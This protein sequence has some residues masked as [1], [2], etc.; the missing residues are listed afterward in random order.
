[1][2]SRNEMAGVTRLLALIAIV[3]V[4][5]CNQPLTSSSPPLLDDEQTVSVNPALD[6]DEAPEPPAGIDPE[7]DV[8]GSD[9]VARQLDPTLP[10]LPDYVYEPKV[11]LS[12]AHRATCLVG[13][14][15]VLPQLAVT[16]RSGD[17]AQLLQLSGEKLTVV[18]FWSAGSRSG[19]EQISRLPLEIVTPFADYGVK[20]LTINTEDSAE[21]LNDLVPSDEAAGYEV[22]LDKDGQAF[23]KIATEVLPRTYLLD[24]EGRVLWFDLGYSRGSVRELTNAIHY[25]LGN[26]TDSES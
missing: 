25:F 16:R 3:C 22:L 12:D 9:P 20:V 21:Q 24:S 17:T 13:V 11:L 4:A 5:G 8:A 2:I 15:D 18:V 6:T 7:S 14:G 10:P 23:A 26:R 1:M 19:S